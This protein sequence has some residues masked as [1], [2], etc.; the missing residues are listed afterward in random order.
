VLVPL[1]DRG[2]RVHRIPRLAPKV[3]RLHGLMENEA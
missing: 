2:W 3:V 1:D